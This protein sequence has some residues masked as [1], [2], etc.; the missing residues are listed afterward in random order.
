VIAYLQELGIGS[1][2]GLEYA[3]G[4]GSTAFELLL[5]RQVEVKHAPQRSVLTAHAPFDALYFGFIG[6]ST[7]VPSAGVYFKY[8]FVL[9]GGF[10]LVRG[11]TL[12]LPRATELE[13]SL[14]L[15]QYGLARQ[16][17]VAVTLFLLIIAAAEPHL[18]D[19]RQPDEPLPRWTFPTADAALVG[20]IVQPLEKIMNQLTIASL[21]AF[22][23]IQAILYIICLLRL[24][25][26]RKQPI[27]SD[28]KL[29]LLDNEENMFDAGFALIVALSLKRMLLLFWK[30][31]VF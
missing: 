24:A 25:E 15:R 1:L 10:L 21:V 27:S 26:I 16:C 13:R 12:V 3:M 29:R 6:M 18:V 11:A 7:R 8:L 5:A 9:L 30:A 28:L 19:T 20:S 23:A 31:F 14:Q 2:P 4:Q 22:L 17:V